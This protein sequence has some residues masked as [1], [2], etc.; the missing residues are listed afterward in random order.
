MEGRLE[1]RFLFLCSFC[2]YFDDVVSDGSCVLF[3]WKFAIAF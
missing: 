2:L 3:S 1:F